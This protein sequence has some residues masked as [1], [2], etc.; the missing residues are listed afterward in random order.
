[1]NFRDSP[2][3]KYD[4]S[5]DPRGIDCKILGWA[6]VSELWVCI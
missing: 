1:M 6:A 5:K 4:S 3:R 2:R